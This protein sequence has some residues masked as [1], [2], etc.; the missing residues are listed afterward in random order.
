MGVPAGM[1]KRGKH[2][3][4]FPVSFEGRDV[5]EMLKAEVSLPSPRFIHTYVKGWWKSMIIEP[6]T[7]DHRVRLAAVATV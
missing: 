7:R 3:L 4:P 6:P 2:K 1:G 5:K